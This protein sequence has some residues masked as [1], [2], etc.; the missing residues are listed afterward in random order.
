MVYAPIFFA[1]AAIE[2]ILIAL[3]FVFKDVLHSVLALS[4]AFFFNSV[5]FLALGQPLLALIQLF[6]MVGGVSTYVFVGVASISF[7]NFRHTRFAALA[8][9][10]VAAFLILS[11]KMLSVQ[12]PEAQANVFAINSIGPAISSNVALFYVI[13]FMVFSV[14]LGSILLLKRIGVKR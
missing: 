9:L 8:G 12:L 11:Y 10:S 2:I 7:S 3:I 5:L 14:S 13:L 1:L 4:M 6:I